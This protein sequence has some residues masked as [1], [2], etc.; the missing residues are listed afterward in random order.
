MVYMDLRVAKYAHWLQLPPFNRPYID[1][2]YEKW[3]PIIR[4]RLTDAFKR[5]V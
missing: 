4:Q 3:R 2:L 5:G 1:P